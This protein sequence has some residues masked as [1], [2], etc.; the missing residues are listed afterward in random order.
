MTPVEMSTIE[1]IDHHINTIQQGYG[2]N[3]T[4][5]FTMAAFNSLMSNLRAFYD[6]PT[7]CPTKIVCVRYIETVGSWAQKFEEILHRYEQEINNWSATNHSSAI[8]SIIKDLTK[9]PKSR[10]QYDT[11]WLWVMEQLSEAHRKGYT[12]HNTADMEVES[13]AAS[14]ESE[15]YVVD[16]HASDVRV[17]KKLNE[18]VEAFR[19]LH[20]GVHND[21]MKLKTKGYGPQQTFG[22]R[23]DP[24]ILRETSGSQKPKA[25]WDT[26]VTTTSTGAL[27]KCYMCGRPGRLKAS[28]TLSNHPVCNRENVP[29]H[30]S[31]KGR[32]WKA[33]NRDTLP[34]DSHNTLAARA[35]R[36]ANA[37][38][39]VSGGTQNRSPPRDFRSGGRER[40]EQEAGRTA[41]HHQNKQVC[42]HYWGSRHN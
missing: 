30:E 32:A 20:L 13:A 34:Q 12:P 14:S 41:S 24:P 25:G 11:G 36:Q 15:Y 4:K 35:A 16:P 6:S 40:T 23:D 7:T 5:A 19:E 3:Y 18:F 10:C 27:A 1:R 39:Q 29:W 38:G 22:G 26:T 21:I 33:Y 17:V 8:K 28:C 31:E 2:G 9:N 37:E 42:C